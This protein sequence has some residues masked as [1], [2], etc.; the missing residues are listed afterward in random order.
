MNMFI[1]L[2]V[3]MVSWVYAYVKAGQILYFKHLLFIVDPL[4]VNKAASNEIGI[5]T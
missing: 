1:I 2:I 5:S 3:A 4:N